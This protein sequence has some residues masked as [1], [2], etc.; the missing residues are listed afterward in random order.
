MVS[1]CFFIEQV[2]NR[3]VL[4]RVRQ[5]L[6]EKGVLFLK[7]IDIEREW[8]WLLV[9]LWNQAILY[10]CEN[11]LNFISSHLKIHSSAVVV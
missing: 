8:N 1:S 10:V 2:L 7:L 5:R 4:L 9:L 11:G 3:S 6:V